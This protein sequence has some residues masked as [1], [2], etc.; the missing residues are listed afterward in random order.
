M[1]TRLVAIG[2][3]LALLGSA[4]AP[5]AE[6]LFK[7]RM[8]GDQEVPPVETDTAGRFEILVNTERT[9]GEYTLRVSSGARVTQSHFHCGPLGINGP[10]IVFL[11]GFHANGWDVD[12]K[13]V[14]NATITDANVVNAA[15]G[16]T[17]AEIFEQAR[18]GNV[19]VNVHSVASPGG[20]VRGQLEP[21]GEGKE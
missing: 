10:V 15:C 14:S 2:A 16:T 4:G 21:T 20:V 18:L 1:T 13:W 9:A 11:A 3:L 7:A 5:G 12:G 19:Y 8:T 17:L 6:E